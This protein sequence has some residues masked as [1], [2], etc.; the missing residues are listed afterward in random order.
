MSKT[1]KNK[2]LLGVQ[3]SLIYINLTIVT[4]PDV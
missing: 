4:Q 3:L 2:K 1:G